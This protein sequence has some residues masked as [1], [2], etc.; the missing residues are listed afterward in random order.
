MKPPTPE[1]TGA[2]P[3]SEVQDVE[4]TKFFFREK[5]ARL[6]VKGT[7]QVQDVEPTKFFFREKYARLGVEGS[8]QSL[9]KILLNPGINPWLSWF[10]GPELRLQR[11][12]NECYVRPSAS[13]DE[14]QRIPEMLARMVHAAGLTAPLDTISQI[15]S[16][17]RGRATKESRDHGEHYDTVCRRSKDEQQRKP[18]TMEHYDTVCRRSEDEQQKKSGDHRRL[19]KTLT[20]QLLPECLA[21]KHYIL[22]KDFVENRPSAVLFPVAALLTLVAGE[23][24]VGSS[25]GI[26][27]GSC[28]TLKMY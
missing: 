27:M 22:I 8:S 16:A 9:S 13:E 15:M 7:R 26:R 10:M 19:R 18:E 3:S 5:H 24:D 11:T 25:S 28:W 17:F 4:P 23:N 14:Q 2:T 1:T 6:G 20:P 12:G 21:Y